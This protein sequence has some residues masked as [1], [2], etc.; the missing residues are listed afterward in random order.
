MKM[1][2]MRVGAIGIE[3]DS[4]AS[5]VVL[6][7]LDNRRA[8]PIWVGLPEA[9]AIGFAIRN[10]KSP[11]P[12]THDLLLDTIKQTGHKVKEIKITDI[13]SDTFIA[14]IVL[15][16]GEEGSDEEPAIVLDARPSDGIAIAML[17]RVPLFVAPHILAE[18]SISA[19]PEADEAEA[20]NFKDFIDTVKASDFT[21]AG[22]SDQPGESPEQ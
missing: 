17:C 18:A 1:I 7:D 21:L 15:T 9:K 3:K 12:S 11:R 20:K 13:E 14:E 10:V 22:R 16:T 6:R 2:E 8:L 19:N 5:V 4:G